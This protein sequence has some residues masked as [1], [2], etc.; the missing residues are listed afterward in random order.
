MQLNWANIITLGNLIC[1]ICA[2]GIADP[3][4]STLLI[5]A[6]AFL[7]LFDGMVARSL[8]LE[9]ELGAY[10]DSLADLVTFGIAPAILYLEIC[11]DRVPFPIALIAISLLAAGTA[12]R[13][14]LF[15]TLPSSPIFRGLPS[16]ANGIFFA[17]WVFSV[18]YGG[19]LIPGL[20]DNELLY[21]SLPLAFTV[22][23]NIR[24]PFFSAKS[25][26]ASWP[27]ALPHYLLI[28]GMLVLFFLVPIDA[29]ALSILWYIL[30]SIFLYPFLKD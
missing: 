28:A 25:F 30:I 11:P 21:I 4:V 22:L 7:D 19:S 27:E 1:G 13:L 14:A 20:H 12:Y 5:L 6:G 18:S 15:N 17:A 9:G 2:I 24:A 8:K 29:V 16:P 23:M 10:L 26:T 3:V